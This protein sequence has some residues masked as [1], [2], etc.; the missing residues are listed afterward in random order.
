M[1]SIDNQYIN[2][3]DENKISTQFKFE[4]VFGDIIPKDTVSPE[5]IAKLNYFLAKLL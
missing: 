4:E 2:K 3:Q 1:G 5:Q